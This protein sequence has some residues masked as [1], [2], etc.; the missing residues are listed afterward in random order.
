MGRKIEPGQP[1]RLRL[2][3][4]DSKQLLNT[5][6]MKAADADIEIPS[7]EFSIGADSKRHIDSLYHH[8]VAARDDL[9]NHAQCLG[10]NSEQQSNIKETVEALTSL[11]DAEKAFDIVVLDPSALSEFKPME[12]VTV[13]EGL[14]DS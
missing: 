3:I 4:T 9:E 6:F 5:C 13:L 11:L 2:T 12:G 10:E 1:R 7:L 14:Q 8:I